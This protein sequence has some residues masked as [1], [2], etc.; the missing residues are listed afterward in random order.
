MAFGQG[1]VVPERL[2]LYRAQH[3]ELAAAFGRLEALLAGVELDAALARELVGRLAGK[4]AVHLRMEDRGL[5]PELLASPHAP[6]RE[7]ARAFQAGMGSLRARADAHALRWLRPGAIERAPGDFAADLRGL[8]EA[9]A[10]R[11]AAEEAHLFPL[12]E[13]A[14]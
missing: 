3:R 5:Y 4:L 10:A 14:A 2:D 6:L 9:L 12:V 8:L 13:R 1:A 7:A 11:V